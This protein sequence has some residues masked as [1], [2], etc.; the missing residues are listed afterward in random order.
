MLDVKDKQLLEFQRSKRLLRRK[1]SI[2]QR[3]R[4]K[5]CVGAAIRN[6]SVQLI[7]PSVRTKTYLN[8]G[9][10]ANLFEH[11]IN[12]DFDWLPGLDL[13]WDIT[14]SIPLAS[15]SLSGIFTEHTLEHFEWQDVAQKVLPEL[16]RILKPGGVIRISVPD[17]EMAIEGYMR[18]KHEGLVDKRF[19]ESGQRA[20]TP[21]MSVTNT[22]RR[23]FETYDIGHKFAWDFQTLE[24]FLWRVGFVEIE[25]ASYMN[26]RDIALLVDFER[27]AKESLYVE[28]AKPLVKPA[29]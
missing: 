1:P 20:L 10:G 13:C 22:F 19:R 11:F 2:F 9:C 25:R 15:N 6:R 18:A 29:A 24:F 8:V 21:L 5:K 12:L 28:A 7:K 26:G 14:K 23:L 17:A 4:V 27:R 3:V 16:F